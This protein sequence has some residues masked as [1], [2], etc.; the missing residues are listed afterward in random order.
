MHNNKKTWEVQAV[1]RLW[2]LYPGICL[3]TEEKVRKNLSYGRK[4]PDI[5][6]AVVQYNTQDTKQ[7]NE[8]EY[9]ERNIHNNKN[10]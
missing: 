3:T 4:C 9:T 6:V 5:P 2:E 1:A 10:T 8:T 7:R